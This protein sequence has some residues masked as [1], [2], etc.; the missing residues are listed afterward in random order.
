MRIPG[1]LLHALLLFSLW[2]LP[3]AGQD[4]PTA[5]QRSIAVLVDV[6]GSVGYKLSLEAKQ[7]IRDVVTGTGFR[8]I[9]GWAS[10]YDSPEEIDP[11]GED[12]FAI[13]STLKTLFQPYWSGNSG[14]QLALTAPGKVFQLGRIGTIRT[15]LLPPANFQ[16]LDAAQI[17]RLL[18]TA[19]PDAGSDYKDGKTCYTMGVA[20]ISESLLKV[21]DQ[22]CYLFVVSD[23]WDDPDYK[24]DGSGAWKDLLTEK[25]GIKGSLALGYSQ[26]VT[27][28]V[29]T[30][31]NTDRFTLIARWHKGPRPRR[32]S[33]SKEY[34]RLSWYAIGEKPTAVAPVAKAEPRKPEDPPAPAKPKAPVF[35]PVLTL[36]GGLPEADPA[37]ETKPA[38]AA[39]IKTFTDSTPFL[40]WQVDQAP[41]FAADPEMEVIVQEVTSSGSLRDLHKLKPTQLAYTPKGGRLRGL[42]AG[43]SALPPLANGFYRV[44]IQEKPAA[45]GEKSA[46]IKAVAAWIEVKR[47]FDWLPWALTASL[48]CAAGV[49]GYSIWSLRK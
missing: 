22:G 26:H 37:D 27:E 36:L 28:Q 10:N 30:L 2:A 7:I 24:S 13:D 29:R 25:L 40:A 35:Q 39:K 15:T 33:G 6:S 20:L 42:A 31:R 21:S 14:P 12:E 43:T 16:I 17:P 18:D 32:G 19:Y 46:G 47:G 48:L 8:P 45:E 3:A 4:K 5:P 49:I 44:T 1:L 23:E 34:L 9:D 11:N 38:S 41:Q